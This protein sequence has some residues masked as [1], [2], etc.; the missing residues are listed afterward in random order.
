MQVKQVLKVDEWF[1]RLPITYKHTISKTFN[2]NK[3]CMDENLIYFNNAVVNLSNSL[4]D[5]FSV[6]GF[7]YYLK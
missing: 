1:R 5:F 2:V 6:I 3:I 7:N 4:C